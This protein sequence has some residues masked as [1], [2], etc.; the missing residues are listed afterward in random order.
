[1]PDEVRAHLFQPFVTGSAHGTG[2]GLAI[3]QRIVTAHKGK[4]EVD[5]FAGGTIFRIYLVKK[6]GLEK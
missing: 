6:K 5:S 3:T 4:I 2:L 1:M